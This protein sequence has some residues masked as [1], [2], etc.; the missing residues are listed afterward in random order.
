MLTPSAETQQ[1]LHELRALGVELAVDD[2]GTG[3]SSLSYLHRLPVQRLKI[4][5]AFVSGIDTDERLQA[6]VKAIIALAEAHGL[7]TV[8][9]G[10]ETQDE[11]LMLQRLGADHLQGYLLGKPM[12]LDAFLGLLDSY[13]PSRDPRRWLQGDESLPIAGGT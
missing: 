6:S 1:N 3:Y 9:E 12:A 11:L 2:F 8:A 13:F 10:V 5:R 4:D 7:E